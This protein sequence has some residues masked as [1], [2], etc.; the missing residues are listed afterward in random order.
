MQW[1]GQEWKVEQNHWTLLL[2]TCCFPSNACSFLSFGNL[3]AC[4]H[5]YPNDRHDQKHH[6]QECRI[7]VA[8]DFFPNHTRAPDQFQKLS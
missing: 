2:Q 7:S 5:H 1:T 6:H 3:T 8:S 4:T